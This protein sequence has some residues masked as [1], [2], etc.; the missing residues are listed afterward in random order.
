MTVSKIFFIHN[1]TY[2]QKK[3]ENKFPVLGLFLK[4]WNSQNIYQQ[5]D[6]GRYQDSQELNESLLKF[7][8]YQD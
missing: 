7:S 2:V 5:A 8:N 4:S 3:L 1:I 6:Y